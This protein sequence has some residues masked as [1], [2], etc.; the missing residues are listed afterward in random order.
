MPRKADSACITTRSDEDTETFCVWRGNV[1]AFACI[2]TRSDEDTETSVYQ[3]SPLTAGLLASPPDPMRILKLHPSTRVITLFKLASPP[4]PM[5]ILKHRG[6]YAS[7]GIHK[8]ASP[9]DPM[10]ILKHDEGESAYPG[11]TLL[12]SPP[13]P[14]RIL[15]PWMPICSRSNRPS[16]ITTRSD[17]DTETIAWVVKQN[18]HFNLHHHPIR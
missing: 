12:A 15:K 6:F 7:S 9:P 1:H 4:D 8:L 5:R 13:D 11:F 14:M 18:N 2:T 16:C 10:R 17:E 3:S